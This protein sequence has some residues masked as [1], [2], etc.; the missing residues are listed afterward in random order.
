MHRVRQVVIP[1]GYIEP[2]NGK[3]LALVELATPVTWSDYVRPVCL[4]SSG[5]LFPG[6]M[7]CYV[8]GWGNIRDDGK[9][10]SHIFFY[11]CV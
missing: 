9:A 5:T 6:G 3:D 8:T 2:Q 10:S 7:Q 11:L 1:S 4:P